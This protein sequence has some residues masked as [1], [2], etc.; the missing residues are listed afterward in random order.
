L[1]L[2]LDDSPPCDSITDPDEVKEL[3]VS[4]ELESHVFKAI[5]NHDV[6]LIKEII[7]CGMNVNFYILNAPYW[8][9]LQDAIDELDYEMP[10]QIVELLIVKGA[11]VN[12]WHPSSVSPLMM[13]LVRNQYEAARLLIQA[14][15]NTN[16]HL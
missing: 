7:S 6:E 10:L 2:D 1:E 15:A 4:N 16:G 3:S 8:T 13:A 12:I 5:E 9:P 14:G 11:D